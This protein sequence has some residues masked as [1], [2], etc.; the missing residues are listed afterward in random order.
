MNSIDLHNGDC[1]EV[2][3]QIDTNKVDLAILDL[4]YGQT[5]CDWDKRIN[6]EN[7]WIELKRVSKITTAYIF[8]TTTKFGYEL[9]KSNEKWFRYD[10]VWSKQSTAGFLN[11]KKM[12]LRSHEMIYVFYNK[13]PT[14]N[15]LEHHQYKPKLT[16]TQMTRNEESVYGNTKIKIKSQGQQ[17]FP[18]LPVSVLEYQTNKYKKNNFHPTEKPSG[19]LEWIIKYYSK[20]GDTV[21]DPTMGSGST[22]VICKK[23]NRSFIGIEL[24]TKYFNI[25]NERIFDE[26]L[27]ES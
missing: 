10:L 9:I 8:F 23:L 14:Y 24:T 17:W 3:K 13:L 27:N 18:K 19:I 12:P 5:D 20:E 2:L 7:L 15:I 26:T 25:A 4:P 11:A 6:L 21:L 16:N 1:L 22:G